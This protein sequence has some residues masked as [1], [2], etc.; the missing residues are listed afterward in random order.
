MNPVKVRTMADNRIDVNLK[1]LQNR[2]M[3]LFEQATAHF[4]EAAQSIERAM[5]S[6]SGQVASY[7]N[8]VGAGGANTRNSGTHPTPQRGVNH[9]QPG[10]DSPRS[11]HRSILEQR[12]A[13]VRAGMRGFGGIQG[14]FG[15]TS[16][17]PDLLEPDLA[18]RV[19]SGNIG[20]PR[21]RDFFQYLSYFAGA[22]AFNADVP[23]EVNPETGRTVS[24][25]IKSAGYARVAA[26]SNAAVW[27]SNVA[28]SMR[29][30]TQRV[31]R[32]IG[33]GF[34]QNAPFV[35]LGYSTRGPMGGMAP[36]SSAW[37]QRIET[38]MGTRFQSAMNLNWGTQQEKQLRENLFAI[39]V[40]PS[41]GG[42]SSTI[43]QNVRDISRDT[44]LGSDQITRLMNSTVRYGTKGELDSLTSTLKNLKAAAAN[45]N[46]T[47][48]Q[49][50]TGLEALS[51]AIT[52]TTGMSPAQS[53]QLASNLQQQTGVS[54]EAIAGMA[55]SRVT[56]LTAMANTGLHADQLAS[57]PSVLADQMMSQISMLVGAS[58]LE[59]LRANWEKTYK[60]IYSD[61]Y[62][63][64]NGQFMGAK[65]PTET[66][67]GKMVRTTAGQDEAM[68][69]LQAGLTGTGYSSKQIDTMAKTL[70]GG[71]K[72]DGYRQWKSKFGDTSGVLGTG[73][74]ERH[75]NE[76]D[77]LKAIQNI[78][79]KSHN[80]PPITLGLTSDAQRLVKQMGLDK[81]YERNKRDNSRP[82]SPTDIA[83]DAMSYGVK[84][85][86][87]GAMTPFG[88]AGAFAGGV[89]GAGYGIL[90][91][92]L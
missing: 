76:K 11:Y 52:S 83:G 58:G 29:A 10:Y 73:Y 48:T 78:M 43:A 41:E 19:R 25:P 37:G 84:W 49:F 67:A 45:A 36:F 51:S 12:Q 22:K 39:G 65:L 68:N 50:A 32:G 85:G 38:G 7:S 9:D 15:S 90:S 88:P 8:V 66:E 14:F 13:N 60:H 31:G 81:S 4:R 64:M 56:M 16:Y 27:A 28:P 47:T 6:Y 89:A 30:F 40:N 26:A 17:A 54:G 23:Y 24:T 3:K 21:A 82:A 35:Q 79:K 80:A 2:E 46:M 42:R 69:R 55:T 1:L 77:K 72:G 75:L 34:D 33:M 87:A 44:G 61:R 71:N 91:N 62:Y 70:L 53:T 74:H 86:V 20:E 59:D 92:V 63:M 57:R 5:Q 18:A